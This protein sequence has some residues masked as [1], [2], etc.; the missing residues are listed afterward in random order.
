[1]RKIIDRVKFNPDDGK[2]ELDFTATT[3]SSPSKPKTPIYNK[4][5]FIKKSEKKKIESYFG[6]SSESPSKRNRPKSSAV[7]G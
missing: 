3:E 7:S 1:M 6:Q 5:L 4:D 2:I